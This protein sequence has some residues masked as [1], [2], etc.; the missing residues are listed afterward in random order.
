L[1]ILIALFVNSLVVGEF[2]VVR[3]LYQG[4]SKIRAKVG[5]LSLFLKFLHCLLI[6][7]MILF[8]T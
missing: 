4:G 3:M 7:Q 8:L 1:L 6:D 5:D 2:F